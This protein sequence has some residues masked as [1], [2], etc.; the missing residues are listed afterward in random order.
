MNNA[1]FLRS[2]ATVVAACFIVA[3]I[4]VVLWLLRLPI[5][6]PATLSWLL[7]CSLCATGL[8]LFT[9]I[10]RSIWE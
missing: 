2:S 5:F 8:A 7:V 1:Y 9:L 3:V 6:N 4:L 10:A